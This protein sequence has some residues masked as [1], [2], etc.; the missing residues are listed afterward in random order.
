MSISHKELM[1]LRRAHMAE[2]AQQPAPAN[3]TAG[4]QPQPQQPQPATTATALSVSH[5]DANARPVMPTRP[6]AGAPASPT[7][8]RF[9]RP[10]E[11]D[12]ARLRANPAIHPKVYAPF[13]SLQGQVPR[14]E[15]IR[16]ARVQYDSRNLE[17]LLAE[18]GVDYYRDGVG[19]TVESA[20]AAAAATGTAVSYHRL[21]PLEA[22][23]DYDL[24]ELSPADWMRKGIDEATGEQ[25]G[26]PC[27]AVR[28]ED[29]T[30]GGRGRWVQGKVLEWNGAEHRLLVQWDDAAA[31][32]KYLPRVYVCFKAED[33]AKF[34]DRVAAAQERRKEAEH[35]L[36]FHLSVDS[37]PVDDSQVIDGDV[38][39]RIRDISINTTALLNNEDN[40][41][42]P[43]VLR[44]IN[45]DYARTANRVTFEGAAKDPA[46]AQIFRQTPIP[47][48]VV[49]ESNPVAPQFGQVRVP[50]HNFPAVLRAFHANTY[51]N[52]QDEVILSLHRVRDEC[53][54]ILLTNIFVVPP[55]IDSLRP[56]MLQD[57]DE[58]Q[59]VSISNRVQMLREQWSGN[60]RE[61]IRDSLK[62]TNETHEVNI[63]VHSKDQY[64]GTKLQRLMHTV[65]FMMQDTLFFLVTASLES[66]VRFVE[67]ACN[68]R[69]AVE[70]LTKVKLTSGPLEV[71]PVE[72]GHDR[73][74]P[75]PREAK[76]ELPPLFRVA[77][78]EGE[79]GVPTYSTTPK[80]F[81]GT[82]IAIFDKAIEKHQDIPQIEQ[83]VLE[84][85]YSSQQQMIQSISLHHP[86]VV[87]WRQRLSTAVEHA[88]QPMEAYLK[89]YAEFH[90]L[91]AID[92]PTYCAE[93]AAANH[94]VKSME[95]EVEKHLAREKHV[96]ATIPNSVNLGTFLVDC[97]DF[98]Q[99]L[100]DKCTLL[101]HKVLEFMAKVARTKAEEV[102]D[103]FAAIRGEL[104]RPM[105]TP[106][107]C[108]KT[109]DF[110]KTIPE[111]VFD[112]QQIINEMRDVFDRLDA[113]KFPLHDDDFIKKWRAIGWPARLDEDVVR[114]QQALESQ[115]KFLMG[116]L[117]KQQESFAREVEKL[118]RLVAGF[119]KRTDIKK[120]AE[121][122]AEVK[123][124]LKD[125]QK[126]KEDA[127]RFLQHEGLFE[128]AEKTNYDVVGHISKDFEPYAALWITADDWMQW[129]NSWN[130]DA[131]ET[132]D[133]E[134]ME[135]N[136][137]QAGKNMVKVLKEPKFKEKAPIL[138]IAEDI[139]AQIDEFKPILPTVKCLRQEGMKE[140]HW[141]QLSK[142]LG[143]DVSPGVTLQT[144]QDVYS[145]DLML[146]EQ[147]L[148][149]VSEVAA[150]EYQIEL[151]LAKMRRD[152][153]PMRLNVKPYKKTGCYIMPKDTV[154]DSQELLDDHTLNTQALSFSPFKKIFEV[155]IETWDSTIKMIQNIFD[156]WKICQKS[157]MY[158]EPIF[159]SD[160]IVRQ[161]PHE[162]KLF[163]QVNRNW[164]FLTVKAHEVPATL[165]Y[166]TTTENVLKL[167][168]ENNE[169]LDKIQRGLLQYLENKRSSFARFYF[170]SDDELLT[171]L[172]EAKDPQKIQAHFRKLFENIQELEMVQGDNEMKGM[173]SAMDEYV[174]FKES[175][176]PRKNVE[177][178]LS[179][180]ESMMKRSLRQCCEDGMRDMVKLGRKQFVLTAPGQIAIAISQVYWTAACE[181]TLNE[182]GS[183]Q[184]Y[185][186]EANSQLMMLVEAVR[187]KLTALQQMNLGGMITIEVHARDIVESLSEDKVDSVFAFEWVSQLRSYWLNEELVLRQV[188]A[189]FI[190]GCEYLG[191]TTRLVITP[192]T[193]R[194]YLTLTGAMHM[195]LGSAPAGPAGTGKTETV[196]DLAKAVAKQCVVFNCQEG[197]TYQSMG[198]FFKGLANS[199]A[200]ACFDEFNRIDVE[201]LS[202]VAQQVSSLQEAAR[203]RQYRIAFEGTEIVVDPT[204]SVFITMNPGYA[205]RTELPDNLKVLFRP[206]AC[207]VP[208]YAM[209]GE[210]R[211]F[212]YGYADSR[213][214]AQKMVATFRLSSEQLSSQDH[215]DFGMRAVNTVISAAGLMKRQFANDPEDVLLLRALRDSNAPK[216]LKEDLLLFNGIISDLFPGIKVPAPDY[217]RFLTILNETCLAQKLQPTALFTK[218][219]IELY[220]MTV[221]RHGQMAVGP[222]MGG[223]S[224]AI[225]VLQATMTRLRNEFQEERFSEVWTYYL[226]PKS[227][228]MSQLYGG[229]DEA[230]DEWKDGLIGELFRIAASDKQPIKK[231]II[232]DGPVDALWIE[233]MNT[234]LDENK[235]LCLISGEIIAM[236]SH[237]NIWFEVEDLAVASPATVS[238]A[239][240]IYLE[241]L[242]CIGIESFVKSW[243]DFALPKTMQPHVAGVTD[244]LLQVLP[245]A[246]QFIST[247][248][249]EYQK[250]VWPNLLMSTFR[251]FNAFM[252][253]FTPTRTY[254]PP[255]DKLELLNDV[256]MHLLVFSLVWGVGGSTD[257]ASRKNSTSSSATSCA[258][259]AAPS[260]SPTSACCTITSTPWTTAAGSSGS[261]ARRHSTRRSRRR[262]SPS[263]SCRLLTCSAT[264]G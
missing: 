253:P 172:S 83:K 178:W 106:E 129:H 24:D 196:K 168:R 213:K 229:F 206:V 36:R 128:K 216:F 231:W 58:A 226:N 52:K 245:P 103:K 207:M 247:Q 4:P 55:Q 192:L 232:F 236:T 230:T 56:L 142:E 110:M 8:S 159:Q 223:K 137:L 127:A 242:N 176:F 42:V 60:L 48:A 212:S 112:L 194:I 19:G 240:M 34:A 11:A 78:K 14:E 50:A 47:R 70:D 85:V 43:S 180:V 257:T 261:N 39:E 121:T 62:G 234:V 210:I 144:L 72:M 6:N 243:T 49:A 246:L 46:L 256:H 9:N 186:A 130:N 198:K 45:S 98:R 111:Q 184:G 209:I 264:N 241:P 250:T 75:P 7:A 17:Q 190:Y 155:E 262:T 235:K 66:Y 63:N 141:Q 174:P 211:L 123:S 158:L 13:T 136:V 113:F 32:A 135:K 146:H 109:R 40:L 37:M 153:D 260:R 145:L 183:L 101:A 252:H 193:D 187:Q 118:Q 208:D 164:K 131:F 74:P 1:A 84:F 140:R 92:V 200:W 81:L 10:T 38:A 5:S 169:L 221:L 117:E 191:N 161:L 175:V 165:Q 80:E 53:D 217:G 116:E 157:W 16:R 54:Q 41:D 125:I 69:A 57:Y 185:V 35:I 64:Y 96:L 120:V 233:S 147:T 100:A 263:S 30:V 87:A 86:L 163:M 104:I 132:I 20:K 154:D 59:T 65:K 177:N 18:R 224:A 28:T 26:V 156:E 204:Y 202:V 73:R 167:F 150:R 152:W 237:M 90:D 151:T 61:H 170:L 220:E 255:I 139:K 107:D 197:M 133:A 51:L 239:G 215:Y 138:K 173:Y 258:V 244:L 95:Q 2:K 143:F 105:D 249:V 124:I 218:K 254:E 89:T 108:V 94:K 162:H 23:D 31:P 248:C 238:R 134:E 25:L 214:L 76:L 102:E 203:S 201:V 225:R 189:Q 166:A 77:L 88:L 251:I 181:K 222:T 126:A 21:L 219:C 188:E 82:I 99:K 71:R 15:L 179:E 122:A 115:R 3:T 149:R 91:L 27:S 182:T 119:Y 114:T 160:D 22:F 33:P 29:G 67:G 68:F 195:F 227:V 93:F 12:K 199:G 44:E 171:I 97:G 228:T 79:G 148:I 205:G 259:R